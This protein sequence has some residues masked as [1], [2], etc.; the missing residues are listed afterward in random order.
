MEEQSF[1][2]HRIYLPLLCGQLVPQAL[3]IRPPSCAHTLVVLPEPWAP[4]AGSPLPLPAEAGVVF[5]S[6]ENDSCEPRLLTLTWHVRTDTP[7][8]DECNRINS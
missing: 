5:I 3:L 1:V 4:S 6:A 2:L 7:C 8:G